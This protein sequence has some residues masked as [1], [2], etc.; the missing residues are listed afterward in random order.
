M[1]GNYGGLYRLTPR[2]LAPI[3]LENQTYRISL[4]RKSDTEVE[5]VGP[6]FVGDHNGRIAI[7]MPASTVV[8]VS[9]VGANGRDEDG[10]GV[11]SSTIYYLYAIFNPSTE[12]VAGLFSLNATQPTLPS[13]YTVYGLIGFVET[14]V[15]AH[16]I[17]PILSAEDLFENHQ[18]ADFIAHRDPLSHIVP[19]PGDG[20]TID[21]SRTGTCLITVDIAGTENITLPDPPVVGREIAIVAHVIQ[22]E[23]VIGCNSP[24]DQAGHTV[25]RFGDDGD[26]IRLYAIGYGS[27]LCWRIVCNDGVSLAT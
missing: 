12:A 21:V 4:V 17:T 6:G 1:K 19:D 5:I 10:G 16:F 24:V 2:N 7:P 3:L 26:A 23:L 22:G 8:N 15:N 20:G 27:N 18:L 9:N 13:G 14:D 11:H 25:L